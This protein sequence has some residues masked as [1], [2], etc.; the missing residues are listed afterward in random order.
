MKK[1]SMKFTY[2][3]EVTD[4]SIK[5]VE[6]VENNCYITVKKINHTEE[7]YIE[8]HTGENIC[9]IG[10]GYYVLEYLTKNENYGVRVF[11]NESKEVLEYYIDIVENVGVEDS[12]PFY[13]D[14]YLDITIESVVNNKVLVLDEDELV[15]ALN[16]NKVNNEQFALAHEVKQRILDEISAN[17]N[18]I[19]N[20]NHKAVIEQILG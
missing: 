3:R 2:L 17:K 1:K 5:T 8:G 9:L 4:Y 15:D 18:R 12:F 20:L 14:L 10:D 7:P 6:D 13:M 19:V 16:E 11:L